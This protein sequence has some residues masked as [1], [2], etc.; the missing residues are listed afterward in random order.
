MIS[1]LDILNVSRVECINRRKCTRLSTSSIIISF[2]PYSSASKRSSLALLLSQ[3]TKSNFAL[4]NC[5][6]S[7]AAVTILIISQ[8]IKCRGVNFNKK[9]RQGYGNHFVK[10]WFSKPTVESFFKKCFWPRLADSFSKC[11]KRLID[12]KVQ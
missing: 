3:L 10:T 8:S 9:T 11:F 2:T 6:S 4:K 1:L 12:E 7:D 5:L